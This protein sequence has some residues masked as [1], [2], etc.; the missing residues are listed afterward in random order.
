MVKNCLEIVLKFSHQEKFDQE[1]KLYQNA[2]IDKE[3][4]EIIFGQP[5][6]PQPGRWIKVLTQCPT[7]AT[8]LWFLRYICYILL[9]LL[10]GHFWNVNPPM[11]LHMF[12]SFVNTLSWV[13]CNIEHNKYHLEFQARGACWNSSITKLTTFLNICF[14]T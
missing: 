1:S 11:P 7:F 10:L 4:S 14:G 8:V 5:Q 13:L 6:S 9:L 2:W 12:L 3:W